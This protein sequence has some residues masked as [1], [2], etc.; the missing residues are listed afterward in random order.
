[1]RTAQLLMANPEFYTWLDKLRK[2]EAYTYCI[3]LTDR[4]YDEQ[5]DLELVV[6]YLVFRNSTSAQLRSFADVDGFLSERALEFAT[7]RRFSMDESEDEFE[8]LFEVLSAVGPE[9]FR[10][11][12][13]TRKRASGAFTV[14]AFEAITL[15]VTSD[16]PK[17][18]K[19]PVKER[20]EQLRSRIPTLWNDAEFIKNS[21]AGVRA[22]TRIPK[23]GGIG[24]RIFKT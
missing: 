23:I 9:I 14:S 16:L 19:F 5:Y 2:L 10:R 13:R 20:T 11:Y 21:G 17:W 18:L 6:R 15:G 1:V 22:T 7:G 4:Q 8:R 24:A 12:D 3:P